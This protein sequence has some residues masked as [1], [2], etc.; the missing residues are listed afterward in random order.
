MAKKEKFDYSRYSD[1]QLQVARMMCDPDVEMTIKQ[2]AT[3]V[4]VTERTIYRWKENPEFIELLNYLSD[5]YMD[6]FLGVVYKSLQKGV[7]K[8]SVKAMELALK[9]QGK[10]VDR[11]EV[12]QDVNVNVFDTREKSNDQLLA[13]LQEMEQRLLARNPIDITSD[14]IVLDEGDDE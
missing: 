8:G 11:K 2:V 12:V 6:A 1:V 7:R 10:L 13:E 5:T 3:E 4:G 14:S 9:R